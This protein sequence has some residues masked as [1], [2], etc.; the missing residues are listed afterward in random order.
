VDAAFAERARGSASPR[1]V[2]EGDLPRAKNR[3]AHL[4]QGSGN[5][6]VGDPRESVRR[7]GLAR[8]TRRCR[9]SAGAPCPSSVGKSVKRTPAKIDMDKL[10]K[11]WIAL[12]YSEAGSQAH[13]DDLWAFTT[14]SD[15][16]ERSPDLCWEAIGEIRRTDG[17]DK[18][19]ANLAAGPLED[20]LV[21]H[22]HKYIDAIERL[23]GH[24]E[25]FRKMLG[26]VWQ[27][28]IADDVWVRLKRV[29]GPTF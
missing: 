20:L 5:G 21:Q 2:A 22:G 28:D 24:D 7:V 19:L 25:Q 10:V 27:N 14:L 4:P 18:I 1:R 3:G 6:V 17:S 12:Q 16:C 11:G 13:K 9:A 15:L 29:A 26:A 23:A 8:L